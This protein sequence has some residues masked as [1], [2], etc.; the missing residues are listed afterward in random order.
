ML[1]GLFSIFL[2]E[3]H[4]LILQSVTYDANGIYCRIDPE[5]NCPYR[6]PVMNSRVFKLHFVNRHPEQAERNGITGEADE[7][8]TTGRGVRTK[9][10]S[11]LVE[12]NVYMDE[13]GYHCQLDPGCD[14]T[15]QGFC[16][17]KLLDHFRQKHPA[18]AWAK[19]FFERRMS[20]M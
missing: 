3:Q 12:E 20:K 10:L 8:P 6:L 9:A 16:T 18:L 2:S 14:Y 11:T 13:E 19:G 17:A 15:V 5:S 7:G 4:Q 1:I